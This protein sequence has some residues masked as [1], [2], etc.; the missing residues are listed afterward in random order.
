VELVNACRCFYGTL[1]R[2]ECSSLVAIKNLRGARL[3]AGSS[4]TSSHIVLRTTLNSPAAS[5]WS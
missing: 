3:S 4:D 2:T 5:R 1:T